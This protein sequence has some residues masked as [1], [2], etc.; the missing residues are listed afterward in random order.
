MFLNH[1]IQRNEKLIEA[2]I[3]F[4]QKR[5]VPPNSYVIDYD[6]VCENA[7]VLAKTANREGIHLYFMTKQFGRNPL[8]A[9]AVA[10]AGIQQAVAVDIDE[11]KVLNRA[12]IKLGHVGHICQI[13]AIDMDW[14]VKAKP[15]VV[16]VF[17]LENAEALSRAA[18]ANGVHM[19]VLLRVRDKNDFIYPGQDG[20]IFL[21]ELPAVARAVSRLPNIRIAGVTS[22]PCL[23]FNLQKGTVENTPNLETLQKAQNILRGME[24][25]PWQMNAPSLTTSATLP[26]LKMKGVTHAEPGHALTG[27]TPLHAQSEQPEK[28]AIVYVSE[29]AHSSRQTLSVFGGG[30]YAR[31]KVQNALVVRQKNQSRSLLKVI[32]PNPENIDYYVQLHRDGVEANVGDTAIFAFRTQ[33]FVT[34]AKVAVVAGIQQGSPRLLGLFTSLGEKIS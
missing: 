17:G 26:F 34:R 25:E 27:T 14:V 8:V 15:E 11:A 20:G 30:F 33:I 21:D 19:N 22:F 18:A 6:A 4:H 16:T 3:E 13:P 1:T 32:K 9:Q 24:L 7:R 23:L 28:P 5:V 12:G 31:G 10:E 2:A 29:I